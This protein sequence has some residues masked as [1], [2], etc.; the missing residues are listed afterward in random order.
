MHMVEQETQTTRPTKTPLLSKFVN[1][2]NSQYRVADDTLSNVIQDQSDDIS[3]LGDGIL[4]IFLTPDE[5]RFVL[6]QPD[7]VVKSISI[8]ANPMR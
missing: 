5:M 2:N 6:F 4:N 8:V 1:D 3:V 7:D